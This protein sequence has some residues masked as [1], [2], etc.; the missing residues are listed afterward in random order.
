MVFPARAD[1]QMGFKRLLFADFFLARQEKVS[2]PPGR[3]PGFTTN[4]RPQ[5]KEA[6]QRPTHQAGRS[7]KK[8]IN[9]QRPTH[10]A[11]RKP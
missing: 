10:Q 1:G 3:N 8:K 11:G 7:P 4:S 6:N 5:A 9:N 2:R